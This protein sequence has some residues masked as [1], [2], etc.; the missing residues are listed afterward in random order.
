[1]NFELNHISKR[2]VE[3]TVDEVDTGIMNKK[4]SLELAKKL[5]SLANELLEVED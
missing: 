5:I 3:V 2:L 1:M 4:E